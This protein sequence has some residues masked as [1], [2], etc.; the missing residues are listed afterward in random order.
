[1]LAD[2]FRGDHSFFF[3][4]LLLISEILQSTQ[5]IVYF[6]SHSRCAS[7]ATDQRIREDSLLDQSNGSPTART[8]ANEVA[9][10]VIDGNDTCIVAV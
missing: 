6:L 3:A 10:K 9:L 2:R 5:Y 1:M 8:L 4:F 7:N